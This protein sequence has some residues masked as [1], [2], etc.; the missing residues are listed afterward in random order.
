[1][2][3][4]DKETAWRKFSKSGSVGDYL[5]FRNCINGATE[6]KPNENEYRRSGA[7]GNGYGG[8]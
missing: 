7:Q 1:M 8:K 3:N 4:V 6:A 5:E 2:I